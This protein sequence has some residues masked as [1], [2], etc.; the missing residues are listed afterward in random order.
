[1]QSVELGA[2]PVAAVADHLQ[3]LHHGV[4]E[5]PTAS[6]RD[7]LPRRLHRLPEL[8]LGEGDTVQP[9]VSSCVIIPYTFSERR[10][11]FSFKKIKHSHL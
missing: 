3:P 2:G 6:R 4:G 7:G 1:M 10:G 9:W 11:S 8:L 5:T